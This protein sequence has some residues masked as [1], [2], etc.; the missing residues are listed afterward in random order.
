V[1]NWDR[2]SRRDAK[3]DLTGFSSQSGA[4][5]TRAVHA[6]RRVARAQLAKLWR[7]SRGCVTLRSHVTTGGWKLHRATHTRKQQGLRKAER[8]WSYPA[9]ANE[10]LAATFM[11][12]SDIRR[13][14]IPSNHLIGSG[15]D[16][17]ALEALQNDCV[18]SF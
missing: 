11:T 17:Q 3:F 4:V 15:L 6:R 2:G 1:G 13:R 5:E 12:Q 18:P 14:R 8:L 9:I 7:N 16:A 10:G